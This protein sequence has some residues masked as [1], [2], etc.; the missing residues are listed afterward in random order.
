MESFVGV[1][2]TRLAPELFTR[3]IEFEADVRWT[4]MVALVMSVLL[5]ASVADNCWGLEV[6]LLI[7]T[8]NLLL[9]VVT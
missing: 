1:L 7:V 4:M 9:E 2:S 3:V 6:V 5:F 8:L